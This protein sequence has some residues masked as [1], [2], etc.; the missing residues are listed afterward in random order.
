VECDDIMLSHHL[1][2]DIAWD[3][4]YATNEILVVS[5]VI[6]FYWNFSFCVYYLALKMPMLENCGYETSKP[7]LTFVNFTCTH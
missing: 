6:Y 4:T 3:F 5:V 7:Q 1:R 2:L